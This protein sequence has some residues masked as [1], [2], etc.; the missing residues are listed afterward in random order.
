MQASS[1]EMAIKR[2]MEM[3]SLSEFNTVQSKWRRIEKRSRRWIEGPNHLPEW[4]AILGSALAMLGDKEGADEQEGRGLEQF[5]V[6]QVGPKSTPEHG[7]QN[8]AVAQ[9]GEDQ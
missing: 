6:G 1:E 4:H 2:C 5:A 3:F 8:E 9:G 7:G